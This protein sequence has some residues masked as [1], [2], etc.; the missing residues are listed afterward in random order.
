[1]LKNIIVDDLGVPLYLEAS[2]LGFPKFCFADMKKNGDQISRQLGDPQM[3]EIRRQLCE[4]VSYRTGRVGWISMNKFM[5]GFQKPHL[6][7]A[8]NSQNSFLK[9]SNSSNPPYGLHDFSW[10]PHCFALSPPRN[11][12]KPRPAG[13]D[14]TGGRR[15]GREP[16][17]GAH[18]ETHQGGTTQADPFDPGGMIW[19]CW[20]LNLD[21]YDYHILSC[22]YIYDTLLYMYICDAQ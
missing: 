4:F 18:T 9:R 8:E 22:I 21:T 1:M 3:V 10:S 11:A 2:I 14:E 13:F 7:A 5:S 19:R 16:G 20:I 6:S 17:D 15:D 12:K